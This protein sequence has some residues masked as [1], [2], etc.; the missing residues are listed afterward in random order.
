MNKEAC[1]PAC[2]SRIRIRQ[3]RKAPWPQKNPWYS[4]TYQHYKLAC[5]TCKTFLKLRNGIDTQGQSFK[6]PYRF[7]QGLFLVGIPLILYKPVAGL[8]LMLIG[9]LLLMR[10]HYLV[11]TYRSTNA[12]GSAPVELLIDTDPST[13][14][15]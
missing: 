3:L 4:V 5:P 13:S 12:I 9:M 7:L 6:K 10:M 11:L 8:A 15:P 1:C 14:F 2:H